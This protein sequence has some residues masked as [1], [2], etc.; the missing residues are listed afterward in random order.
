[1]AKVTADIKTW[2]VQFKVFQAIY[3]Y[4]TYVPGKYNLTNRGNE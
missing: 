4:T 2:Y 3:S 1:M